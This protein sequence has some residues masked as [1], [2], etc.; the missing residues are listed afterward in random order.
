MR[1]GDAGDGVGDPGPRGDEGDA[2]LADQLGMCL[3]HVDR[4]P[5][6]AHVDDPNALCV[7]AHPDRHDVAAAQGKD[8]VDPAGPEEPG[9]APGRAVGG[10]LHHDRATRVLWVFRSYLAIRGKLLSRCYQ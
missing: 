5:L 9:D 10:E 2:K 4:G 6:V 8:P 7:K 1:V 3:R